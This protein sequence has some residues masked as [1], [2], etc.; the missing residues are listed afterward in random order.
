[1]TEDEERLRQ[2]YEQIEQMDDAID[3]AAFLNE[4]LSGK[5]RTPGNEA[6]VN[7]VAINLADEL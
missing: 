5:Q 7:A 3:Q 4:F 1:M 6:L 2:A